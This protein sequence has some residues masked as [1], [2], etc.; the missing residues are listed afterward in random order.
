MNAEEAANASERTRRKREAAQKREARQAEIDIQRRIREN[1]KRGGF[2]D[3]HVM[4]EVMA[5][6]RE[7]TIDG[8]RRCTYSHNGDRVGRAIIEKVAARLT[9]RGYDVGRPEY[10]HGSDAG[11]YEGRPPHYSIGISW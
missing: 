7:A 2:F 1:T 9:R 4:P 10:T 6:I 8:K 3:K 11:F 5:R